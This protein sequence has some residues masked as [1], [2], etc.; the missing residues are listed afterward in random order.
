MRRDQIHDL[1][2]HPKDDRE[3]YNQISDT[4]TQIVLAFAEYIDDEEISR[5][6][7]ALIKAYDTLAVRLGVRPYISEVEDAEEGERELPVDEP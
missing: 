1:V 4:F 5:N 7:D 6:I 2:T 3:T